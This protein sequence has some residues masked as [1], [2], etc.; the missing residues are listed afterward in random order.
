[1]KDSE[2]LNMQ[3]NQAKEHLQQI[4]QSAFIAGQI[5]MTKDR[6]SGSRAFSLRIDPDELNLESLDAAM[7]DIR[8]AI[9]NYH[10]VRDQE[11]KIL[12]RIEIERVTQQSLY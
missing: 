3:C 2:L 7:Q 4:I 8:N 10:T 9:K 11:K 1:M 5:Q 12:Q 6:K